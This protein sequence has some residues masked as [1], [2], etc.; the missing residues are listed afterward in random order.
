MPDTITWTADRILS[1]APDPSSAKA[2]RELSS[3]RKWQN[4]GHN[5]A[6][7]WGEHQGSA[8][9][10]YQTSI[11]LGEPAFK[12]TC[13]SRKFP[14]KHGLGLFLAFAAEPAAFPTSASPPA[15][16]TEWLESRAD[17]A[18]RAAKRE[19][20][21]QQ[22]ADDPEAR[23]RTE[24]AQARTA[25]QRK[26]RVDQGVEE[27]DRWV[28][29]LLRGG[30]SQPQIRSYSFWENQIARLVDAQMPG[31]SRRVY[32]MS[33]TAIPSGYSYA[34]YPTVTGHKQWHE[35]LL[36]EAGKLHLLLEAYRRLDTLPAP[37]QAEVRAL[38]GWTQDQGE[39]LNDESDAEKITDTWI[40]VGQ[41]QTTENQLR[42]QRSFLWGRSSMR[43][44]IFLAFAFGKGAFDINLAEQTQFDATLVFFPSAYPLRALITDQSNVSLVAPGFR[45]HSILEAIDNYSQA[46][47]RNPWLDLFPLFVGG[48][49][50]VHTIDAETGQW[51][52]SHVRDASGNSL[53]IDPTLGNQATLTILARSG[54][55]PIMLFGTWNGRYFYPFTTWPDPST[56]QLEARP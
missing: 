4:M 32:N 56:L 54:G 53:I 5:D 9:K 24:K 10:P 14:C 21:E 39:L 50:P 1:L 46:L 43:P 8:S 33:L 18:E 29:D 49:I 45:A 38:V 19:E 27:L 35:Q 28:C 41:Q 13:P 44:A 42:T 48:V 47:R 31:L 55:R 6:A 12:C 3:P 40:V 16:V 22:Q 34:N 37:L 20:R 30:F 23:A 51:R 26:A 52:L 11:D 7:V 2:G 17:K 15:W 25:A 36:E